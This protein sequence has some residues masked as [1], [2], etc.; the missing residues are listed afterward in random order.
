MSVT[1]VNWLAVVRANSVSI[2]D[3]DLE[4]VVS[5]RPMRRQHGSAAG[6]P[7][8]SPKNVLGVGTWGVWRSQVGDLRQ[9][10]MLTVEREGPRAGT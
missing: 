4:V 2:G 3:Q 10:P 5:P 1:D 7:R 8:G 9:L 6:S